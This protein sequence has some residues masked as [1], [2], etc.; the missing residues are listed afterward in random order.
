MNV[1]MH[2]NVTDGPTDGH[3]QGLKPG[4]VHI[5]QKV[6]SQNQEAC[7]I[8]VKYYGVERGKKNN[9]D[10]KYS[11]LIL[12]LLNFIYKHNISILLYVDQNS[13]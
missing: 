7:K 13:V 11:A 12:N 4:L 8:N 2:V 10:G 5:S 3:E 1:G 6:M 9:T